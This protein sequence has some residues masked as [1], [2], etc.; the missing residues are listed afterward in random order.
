MQTATISFSS[1][2]SMLTKSAVYNAKGAHE[3]VQLRQHF[4]NLIFEFDTNTAAL[5]LT[6]SATRP[7]INP[8]TLL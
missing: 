2:G 1:S 8:S 6:N 7:V 4:M 5:S 3:N